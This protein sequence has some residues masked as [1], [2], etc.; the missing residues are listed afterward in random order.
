MHP[1][2]WFG[3]SDPDNK[4]YRNLIIL[5]NQYAKPSQVLLDGLLDSATATRS[6]VRVAKQ[7]LEANRITLETAI[8]N[9]SATTSD[10]RAYLRLLGG[11]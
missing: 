7:T 10:I 5:D 1:G 9:D 6:N 8:A 3:W 11:F 2:Q 4:V